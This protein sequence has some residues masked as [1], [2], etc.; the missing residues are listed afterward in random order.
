MRSYVLILH[1]PRTR[2]IVVGALGKRTFQR[3]YYFYVGSA[4]RGRIERHIR[5]NATK[6]GK[7]RWHIDYLNCAPGV[8][9]V[10][11]IHSN[12]PECV[13]AAKLARRLESIPRFGC[14]DCSCGSHLFYSKTL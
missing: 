5:M 8:K 4:G 13:L 14:S 3:G 6:T 9:L 12:L 11:V 7:L 2:K 1:N 10:K